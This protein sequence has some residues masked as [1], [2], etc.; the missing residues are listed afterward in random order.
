MTARSSSRSSITPVCLG[1]S[2]ARPS[3]ALC[4]V[5]LN[6]A[7]VPD[8]NVTCEEGI[9]FYEI[10]R[11]GRLEFNISYKPLQI[12]S[13]LLLLTTK[14]T[15][16]K[17]CRP[18]LEGPNFHPFRC[19]SVCAVTSVGCIIFYATMSPSCGHTWQFLEKIF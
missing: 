10:S 13:L 3:L 18:S 14:L 11:V 15:K 8:W 5:A 9:E 1:L 7:V 6:G 12:V 16:E 2:G 17:N 19:R 4:P